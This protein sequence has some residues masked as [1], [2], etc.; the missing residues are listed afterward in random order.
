MAADSPA[1]RAADA[2]PV[3]YEQLEHAVLMEI[4]TLHPTHPTLDELHLVLSYSRVELEEQ[5]ID[6][7]L[8]TL[9]RFGLVRKNGDVLEPTLAAIH[10]AEVI[11]RA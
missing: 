3:N 10:A 6:D 1:T 8:Q 7:S 4:I 11:E 2:H 5:A 9:G